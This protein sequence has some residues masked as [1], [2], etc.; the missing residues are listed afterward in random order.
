MYCSGRVWLI[1]WDWTLDITAA[2][3][4]SSVLPVSKCHSSSGKRPPVSRLKTALCLFT[5]GT[6]IVCLFKKTLRAQIVTFCLFFGR[7]DGNFDAEYNLFSVY[8]FCVS[9]SFLT[10]PLLHENIPLAL[11]WITDRDIYY[12]GCDLFTLPLPLCRLQS[13]FWCLN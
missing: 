3:P 13:L 7:T 9:V 5:E 1:D 2:E 10:V 11:S 6:G 8:Y 12:T 4:G